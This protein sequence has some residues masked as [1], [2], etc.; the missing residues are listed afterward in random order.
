MAGLLMDFKMPVYS[1]NL[2]KGGQSFSKLFGMDYFLYGTYH[3]IGLPRKGSGKGCPGVKES[4]STRY[5]V[6]F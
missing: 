2:Q 3:G 6:T 1:M 5:T 4:N